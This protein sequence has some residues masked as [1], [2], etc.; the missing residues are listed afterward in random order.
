MALTLSSDTP[1]IRGQQ[2]VWEGTVTFDN[3]Y[4]TGGESFTPGDAGFVSFD[5]VQVDSVGGYVFAYDESNEKILAYWVDTTV[6]GAPMAQVSNAEDLS[7]VTAN[8]TV[9]GY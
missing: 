7:S 9:Y 1:T 2:K 6:D 4:P 8:V 3:S 5:R